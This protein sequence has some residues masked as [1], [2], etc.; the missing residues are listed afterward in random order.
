MWIIA[1]LGNPGPRYAGTRH[2]VGFLVVD[3]I[4]SRCGI[5][6]KTRGAYNVGKGS[7]GDKDIILLEPL[8]FMNRSGLA[9]R[10]IMKRYHVLP[11]NL[12]VIQDDIDMEIGKL[13]I[14][15]RGSSGGH[16]GVE[17]IIETIGTRDFARVKIGV[18]REAGVSVE[19][20]VLRKFKKDD[21]PLI[22]GA[23]VRAADAVEAIVKEG[24]EKAMNWFNR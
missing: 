7:M 2:N 12:I 23:I 22:R 18:G 9:V 16:R 14:R 4:S 8:T 11:E 15:K 19:D 6:V 1:G 17:S 21:I 24:I 10:D 3:E 5:D 13:K 20:Y